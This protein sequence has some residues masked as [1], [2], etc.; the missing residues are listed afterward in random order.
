MVDETDEQYW[1]LRTREGREERGVNGRR[2]HGWLDFRLYSIDPLLLVMVLA[3]VME[4]VQLRYSPKKELSQLREWLANFACVSNLIEGHFF[5]FPL[6]ISLESIIPSH[7]LLFL[8]C[9]K[10]LYSTIY[11]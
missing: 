4:V 5:Y 7:C 6:Q 8:L 11:V 2:T 1:L 9:L 10:L 3:L